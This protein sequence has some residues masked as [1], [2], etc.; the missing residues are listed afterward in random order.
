M[1]KPAQVAAQVFLDLVPFLGP[2]RRE[3]PS[4]ARIMRILNRLTQEDAVTFHMN[5][6]GEVLLDA[7]QL[8]IGVVSSLNWLVNELAQSSGVTRASILG[9]MRKYIGQH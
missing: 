3:A 8:V 4:E 7:H 6:D 2:T 1:D 5:R 9:D